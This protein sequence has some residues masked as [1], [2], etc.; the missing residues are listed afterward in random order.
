MK[1]KAWTEKVVIPTY[2]V[3]KPEKNPIFLE[4]RVYQGSSGAV[5]PHPVI[6]KISDTKKDKVW[7][8]CY[9]ENDYIKIMILP[10]LGGRIQ[11]AFDKVKKRHFV[12]YNEVIKPALV[13]LTG[14]WISGGIEFNW[15]QHHRPS[16]YD[17]VDYILEE[18]E[19]G[20]ATVWCSEIER[21][22]RTKGMTGFTLYPDK[23]YLEIKAKI[24]NRTTLPQTFLWWANPA[25][26]VND[27]Y[28][29]VFPPDVNAVF[30]H[31]K[32]DVSEFPIAKGEYYKVNY[33]PGT[34]ISWYK[35]IPVPTSYM[36]IKSDYNFVGGYENDSKGGL[37]HVAN[38]HISPGKKQWTWGNGDFGLA[39]DRNLTDNNGPYI[40]LMCGVYTDNQ[41]DFSWLM[42]YE[43][44][45]FDQYFMPYQ[46]VGVIKNA[47]KD[48][49]MNLEIEGEKATIKVYATGFF[50][51]ATVCLKANDTIYFEEQLHFSPT[52]S[53]VWEVPINA[54]V[55]KHRYTLIIFSENGDVLLDWSIPEKTPKTIPTAAKPAL[56]P[57][58]IEHI[59]TLFLN[60]QHIEQY[61]HATYSP[62]DY[63]R[64]ALKRDP[65][66][67]RCNNAMGKWL[68]CRGKFVDAE[69]YFRKALETQLQR[70]PNPYDGEPLFNLGLSLRYQNKDHEAYEYFYKSVWNAAYMDSGYFQIAQIE[71]S[72][73]RWAE[74]LDTV[75]RSLVRN[76]HNHKARCLKAAILRQT[77]ATGQALKWIEKSLKLDAFN[78]ALYFEK[79]LLGDIDALKKMQQL[80][81]GNIH[82]YIEIAL[83][84]DAAGLHREA[85]DLIEIGIREQSIAYPMAHYFKAWF[86]SKLGAI[87]ESKK[88]IQKAEHCL[89]DYCFPNRIEAVTALQFAIK[90]NPEGAK[91]PYYLGNFWYNSRQ[92]EEALAS[93]EASRD[94]DDTFPTIHRNLA[95]AYYNKFNKSGE[96][97]Q[98]ME[99]AFQLDSSDARIL[100]ELYQ[101]YMKLNK[102]VSFRFDFLEKYWPLVK[103]RDDL[104]IEWVQLHILTGKYQKAYDL[105]LSRQFRPWEGGEG[106]VTGA[107]LKALIGLSKE[108]I[109]LRNYTE[110]LE[111]LRKAKTYPHNLGEGKLQGAQENEIDYWEGCAYEGLGDSVSAK[112]SW[113]KAARGLSEP[114]I[115]WYYNDQQPDTIFFQGLALQ[116]LGKDEEAQIRFEKLVSYGKAH[117]ND[118]IKIDY[119]AVSLPDL[120]VWEEDLDTRNKIHCY[121]LM[122]LGY[123]GMGE[124][125]ASQKYFK[126]VLE[127]D[128]GYLGATLGCQ[129]VDLPPPLL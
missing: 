126:K 61:R 115:A 117:L 30:D 48:L 90:A 129:K 122:A 23:A 103:E 89:P 19:D 65:N 124:N 35:N 72:K 25:V 108:Q 56:A 111:L 20:S 33:A 118:T 127:K 40:E 125:N 116:K 15:P 52:D 100:L 86:C 87:E 59:E 76:W 22:S 120:T 80:M 60:G 57:E 55:P 34:D 77:C 110:S 84:Y 114:I 101:L 45:T 31:G 24:Y 95:L 3:G 17:P 94:R 2:E 10:E 73:R 6:E 62:L 16:T 39:W 8:A 64:E 43:E 98:A 42:P 88:A 78:F 12:Y 81:R 27:A 91:A 37:L 46:N 112:K 4:K 28:Q 5:Y 99:T 92:Y 83:D 29:S 96:A 36:A 74:A 49:L 18:N 75:E 69:E 121:Y 1:A 41:P 68:L 97:L 79:Y 14:P 105:L 123:Q 82:N 7:Q 53:L 109:E 11:M 50:H 44:K 119:F 71:T 93:W 26:A 58:D 104:Y 51:N 38:H 63:Y 128:C 107:Y 13:G 32:R 47:N 66:D 21:M 67:I 9:L 54:S 70:N 102:P 85:I 106:K 113:Q